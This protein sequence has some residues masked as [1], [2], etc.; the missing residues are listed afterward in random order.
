MI[1]L[2]IVPPIIS[3]TTSN[4]STETLLR[5]SEPQNSSAADVLVWED[6]G[7]FYTLDPHVSGDSRC[8]WI[9]Y[10]IYETLYT[11]PFNES[12][13]L[14]DV[15]LLAFELPI[16]S[17]D[18]LN[19]TITLRQGIE[20]QDGTPFNASCVKW[21]IERA[22]KIFSVESTIRRFT[23]LLVGGQ[24]LVNAASNTYPPP[25]EFATVFD[26][27]IATSDAI[28]VLDTYTIRFVLAQ[29]FAGFLA[30]LSAPFAS[31][32]SP[33]YAILHASDPAWAT[34]DAYG[35]D[36][37]EDITWMS[38]HSCGT[39]PYTLNVVDW[40]S[41]TMQKWADY[42]RSDEVESSLA[43]PSYA[44]SIN[45]VIININNDVNSRKMNLEDG[46]IDGCYTPP[47]YADTFVDQETG[48]SMI[49]GVYVSNEGYASYQTYFGFNMAGI[50]TG[51]GQLVS[52]FDDI[53][54]RKA[55]SWAFD[56]ETFIDLAMNGQAVQSRGPLPIGSF[57]H[58]GSAF[59]YDY[60]I[61]AAVIEWNLAMQNS[62]FIDALN[63]MNCQI[64]VG[65]N[66]GNTIRE[67]LCDTFAEALDQI[68]TSP[69]AIHTGLAFPLT[70]DI[71]GLE[72]ANYLQWIRDD[73]LAIMPMGWAPEFDDP[74]NYLNPV[75]FENGTYT[76]WV[77][78]SNPEISALYLHQRNETNLVQRK[79]YLDQLQSEIAEECPYVWLYQSTEF[80]TWRTWLQGIGLSYKPLYA[81]GGLY[82]Y[83]IHKP[84]LSDFDAPTLDSPPDFEIEYG[85]TG[86]CI[87]WNPADAYP[88]SYRLFV[89]GKLE[90][91]G[92]W[93][94]SSI[95]VDLDG[96][97][98][99]VYEY[100]LIVFDLALNQAYD[101]VLVTVIDSS[102]TTT[103]TSTTTT[104]ITH[105][106]TVGGLPLSDFMTLSLLLGLGSLGAIA[107]LVVLTKLKPS[108]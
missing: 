21:N 105:S 56:Y 52:P 74:D 55:V 58:N 25:P 57:G 45:E 7:G 48:L 54:F 26:N 40:E 67:L 33:T 24:E 81:N 37:G 8:W 99:G 19:Y 2:L 17:N 73:R 75:A 42:W 5:T 108:Q 9:F 101:S 76:S 6:I 27:W 43:P 78:Y 49:P 70:V 62:S 77:N 46:L 100:T 98:P 22:I 35:V 83:H 31:M 79:I 72:W 53:H 66:L 85:S 69:S 97:T 71:E 34:W 36:Y 61:T 23:P 41:L 20:F 65:Y 82:F 106:Y 50:M 63:T 91:S 47:T 30:M 16:V 93:N 94:G 51:F 11:Y 107:V 44:G 84:V 60:N 1:V 3:Y 59:G 68:Y 14:P 96:L 88:D 90:E 102:G 103:T 4:L 10:N 15:P 18:S 80:R 32:M 13:T 64:Y 39:G 92:F 87:V 29:P 86:H 12:S 28:E 89:D 104:T 38:D 95:S